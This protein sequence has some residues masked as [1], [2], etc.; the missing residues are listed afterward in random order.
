MN[1]SSLPL[2]VA[3]ATPPAAFNLTRRFSILALACVAIVAGA[4]GFLLAR[5]V[6]ERLLHRD[7]TVSMEFVQSIVRTDQT[8]HYFETAG[9]G[10]PDPLEDTFRH[11]AE[12]PDV[13]RTN[14]YN[15]ERRAIWSTD[16]A[17]MGG[18][19]SG[20]EELDEA[21]EGHLAYESGRMSKA[22]HVSAARPLGA[23]SSGYFIEIYVPVRDTKGNVVGVVEL[24]KAPDEL[25]AAIRQAEQSIAAGAAI[26]ALLLYAAL[27]GIVRRAD[28]VMRDQQRRLVEGER[29]TIVGEMASAVAH[30]IRNPL[31][32]IRT[33]VEV[34]LDRDPGRFREP[35]EDI[36]AEV[37]KIDA[38]VRELLEFSRP[39]SVKREPVD[40]NGLVRAQLADA[41][42]D[43]ARRDIEVVTR[44]AS[45]PPVALGD[46]V[47]LQQVLQSLVSNAI[48]ALADHGRL[49]VETS[50]ADRSATIVVRDDGPG[51]P[52][53]QLE[54]VFKPF[55][56][57]KA[58]G[59]G[60]GLP[61]SRR[62]V[63]RMGGTLTLDSREGEGTVATVTLPG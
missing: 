52:A 44:F 46:S 14:V 27:I 24:Y 53:A 8:A 7:A 1:A 45:P 29:F 57:T 47:L 39:G 21:L 19:F 32:A 12:M 23:R 54:N 62:L 41:A 56:T 48:E 16:P 26:G 60:L 9:S 42:I 61:L 25:F 22:E 30:S 28:A 20:N 2:P 13:L 5:M 4:L 55:F 38:W 36:V 15:T 58:R 40:V 34:A 17:V 6:T 35:A 18:R 31:S 10:V 49:Q 50:Y 51:I 59:T 11:F 3:A 37:D 63:Q 33:S 43:C